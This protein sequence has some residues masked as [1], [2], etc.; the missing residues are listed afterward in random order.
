MEGLPEPKHGPASR[1]QG[2]VTKIAES[3]KGVTE[4]IHHRCG[5]TTRCAA[6]DLAF[7][8]INVND[9]VTKSGPDNK[10]GTGTP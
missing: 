1:P 7:P 6:G 9:S 3:V 8:A 10:Y 5:S 4:E 2:A